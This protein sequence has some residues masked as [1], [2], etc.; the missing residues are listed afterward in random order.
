MRKNIDF[1]RQL[2]REQTDAETRLWGRLRNRALGAKFR[3]Q[4]T[5][6][7]YVLDFWCFEERLA[8]ELDG[9]H[10]FDP[11]QAA[12]DAERTAWLRA[13]GVRVARFTNAEVLEDTDEVVA[14]IAETL[15]GGEAAG[16]LTPA[17]SPAAGEREPEQGIRARIADVPG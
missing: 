16:P 11:E 9:E 5:F 13:R 1:A 2:R 6:G 8:I 7:P 12:Y 15:D 14:W 10:H 4:A 3:R 17:L